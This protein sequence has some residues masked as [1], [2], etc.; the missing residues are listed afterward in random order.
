VLVAKATEL[1]QAVKS[2]GNNL[3]SVIE[4]EDNEAL[5]ILRARHEKVALNLAEV[6]RYGQWQEAVKARE[7]LEKSFAGAVARYTYYERLLGREQTQINV[8]ELEALDA[9]ALERMRLRSREPV[10]NP[11]TIDIDIAADLDSADG[12]KISSYEDEELALLTE[13]QRWENLAGGLSALAATAGLVPTFEAAAKPMGAGAG[14]HFGGVN[15]NVAAAAGAAVSRIFASQ[16][17]HEANLSAKV[18]SYARREQEW[19]FQSNLAAGEITQIY[20]QWR[21][22]QIREAIAEREWQNHQQQIRHAEEIERFLTD[23]KT[24]K[25]SNKE[26]YTWLRREV[27]GLYSQCFQFAYDV[28]KRA[29]RALQHELGDLKR[30]F[31]GFGYQSG[32]QGLLA[33]EKL[34]LDVKRMEMA[35]HELNQREYELTKHVSLRQLDPLALLALRATGGCEFVVPEELFDLDCPGHYFRRI[36]SVA[37]SIP[38]V[39]GPFA[40]VNATLTLER[41]TIRTS[42]AL[43]AGEYARDDEDA[44]RFSDNF[45]SVQS[46]VTS[47]ANQDAGL[48]ETNLR[49]ERYLPFEGSGA[50]SKWRLELPA[51]L[52]QFDHRTISDVV[53]HLRYTAREGGAAL[54]AAAVEHLANQVAEANA[55]GSVRLLSVR[56]DFPTEWAR[57]KAITLD[58]ATQEAP[59]SITLRKEHYPYWAGT[60]AP[61]VLK[62]VDVLVEPEPETSPTVTVSTAPDGDPDRTEHPLSTDASLGGLRAGSLS[63]PLPDALGDMIL[64]VDDNS[65]GD[66][67]LALSWGA[68]DE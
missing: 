21:A 50:V 5:A 10:V 53:L 2:L 11:R 18:G 4:K 38:C 1:A 42:P 66:I 56:S 8:P 3:L 20:K 59:L 45:G 19:A 61:I 16:R 60:M 34:H 54:K 28:A 55:V 37:L 51:E 52:P 15:L 26:L 40:G 17:R 6:V 57:F 48:F 13:A 23:P 35:Y 29:E 22:A 31:V 65:M 43:A 27:R 41:S 63:D 12:K 24:G 44:E 58:G 47:G 39:V 36:K 64:Y 62:H 49:D 14:V 7:G 67:W 9:A 25:T 32:K 46:I 68:P 33:G 30:S